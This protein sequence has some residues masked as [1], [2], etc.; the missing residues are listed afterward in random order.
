MVI[1][2]LVRT[3]DTSRLLAVMVRCTYSYIFLTVKYNN[4][5]FYVLDYIKLGWMLFKQNDIVRYIAL[6]LI[7]L[8]GIWPTFL[9]EP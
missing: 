7:R 1:K 5:Y 4:Y 9:Y 8:L 3:E 6:R 2:T